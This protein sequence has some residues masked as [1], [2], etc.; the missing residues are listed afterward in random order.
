[1]K[2]ILFSIIL[3]TT[4]FK[5]N[6]QNVNIPDANFKA[7]LVGNSAINT[8]GDS[9]IQLIEAQNFTGTISCTSSNISDLTGIEFF[10]A[11]T[12]L[13]CYDN[14]L[15]SLNVTNNT[16]LTTLYFDN[17][18]ITSI[19]ISQNL[20][21]TK[22]GFG[23]NQ[24]T[25]I[26]LTQNI[27]LT[28]LICNANQLTNLD[29]THNIALQTLGCFGNQL[30]TL[31]LKN[32]SNNTIIQMT[33]INNPNLNCIQVDDATYSSNA[34]TSTSAFAFD[35]GVSFSENCNYTTSIKNLYS[36]KNV[37]GIYPNPTNNKINFSVQTNAQITNLTG[38]IIE[39]KKNVNSIDLF[40]QSSG[41]YFVTLIDD[42]GQ[43]MQRSKI[44]KE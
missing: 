1:M 19:N 4:L 18:Q 26:D 40:E 36:N 14:Q 28:K 34:W 39:N 9:E 44:V 12:Y 42:K 3:A 13:D 23:H 37:I 11:L 17:N 30:T 41:I 5:A 8:N 20:A 43:V 7:Y 6:A 27:A 25:S 21:L 16:A 32:G 22:L 38:Q 10:T 24:I 35:S 31:N 2:K 33:T 15:T 29:L